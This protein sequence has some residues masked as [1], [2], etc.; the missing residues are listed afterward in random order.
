MLTFAKDKTQRPNKMQTV[1]IFNPEHDMALAYNDERFTPPH[2]GRAMRADLSFLPTLWAEE[3][4]TVVVDDVEQ[5]LEKVR[6]I[7][8][9]LPHVNYLTPTQLHR[10]AHEEVSFDV[11][12]WDTAVRRQLLRQ[13]FDAGRLPSDETLAQIRRC[14]HRQWAA[15][16]LAEVREQHGFTTG[17]ATAVDDIGRLEAL[18]A[19]GGEWVVK[20]P[21]SC[22]GRGVRHVEG[23]LTPQLRSWVA[24][25]ISQQG[26]IMF[27][28]KYNKVKDFG[29]EFESDGK[30]HIA[31]RG[32]SLFHTERGAYS[33]N[34]LATEDDK[35]SLIGRYV[36]M[37]RLGQ[38]TATLIKCL[39]ARLRNIYEG[40][41]GVDMMVVAS[42]GGTT[43]CLV[44]PCVEINL[45]RTMGHVAL[46]LQP[47][48]LEPQQL[49]RIDYDGHY[50]LKINTLKTNN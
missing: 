43:P 42:A 24:K 19:Q 30:G 50:H 35:L 26:S 34:L 2:A 23:T 37:E 10:I 9:P 32:L 33:G 46:A 20:A 40:P 7:K 28:P 4:D 17:E 38:I 29:M 3:G 8:R 31:Y 18:T 15:E 12:G 48:P 47:T 49:M 21:W 44:H 5:A 22:S 11:W 16:V 39:S 1:H 45:R 36:S 41:L 13:G 14:S 6:H 27:E 25:I